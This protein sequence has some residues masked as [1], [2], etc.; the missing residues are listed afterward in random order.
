VI[1][2]EGPDESGK[3][4]LARAVSERCGLPY[5]HFVKESS[6]LDYLKPLCSLE[7]VNAVLDRWIFSEY[8]YSK[9]M[10]RKFAFT[11]KEWHNII[12]LTLAHNPV[13]VLC[14]HIPS[15]RDY[16]EK[17]YLPYEKWSECIGLYREF[18]S[19]HHIN[20][21]EYDYADGTPIVTALGM[22]NSSRVKSLSWWIPMWKAGYGYIGSANP[23]Y[24]LVAERI[25]PNNLNNLPFET[26]PTGQMLSELLDAT[27][28]PLGKFAVTN[29]VKSFRRDTR[30]P[31][32]EDVALLTTELVNLKPK[33]VVFMGEPSKR[34]GVPVAKKLGIRSVGM[35]HLGYYSHRGITDISPLVNQWNKEVKIDEGRD[36]PTVSFTA[37]RI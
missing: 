23:D 9:I 20:V 24:L 19:N 16:P 35:V 6:Y 29:M 10:R 2:I 31:N 1:I 14:T 7:L 22:L 5:Y 33:V 4:T 13:I 36:R 15:Q 18:F 34:F 28:T 37:T 25:G 30:P 27:E 8:P 26:G 11:L 17:Q 12:L 32:E 3:S 21:I